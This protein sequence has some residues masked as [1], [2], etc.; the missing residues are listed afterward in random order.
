VA[1]N[2][3]DDPDPVSEKKMDPDRRHRNS[4]LKL[5]FMIKV[6]VKNDGFNVS[7]RLKHK[8]EISKI[9]VFIVYKK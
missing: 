2:H 7:G 6:F 5:F 9:P 1:S 3:A 4:D 8:G